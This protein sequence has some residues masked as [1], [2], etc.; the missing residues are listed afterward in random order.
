MEY[1]KFTGYVGTY[2]KGDSKGIYSFVLDT[3]EGKITD[4]QVAGT[5]E[6]PTYLTI[7]KDQRFLYSV[8]KENTKGGVAA[9]KIEL[10]PSKLNLINT[11]LSEGS[12]PCHV[13]IDSQQRYLFSTNYHKGTVESYLID[14]HTGEI[15]EPCSV[16]QHEG[17]GPDERQEKAHTHFAGMTPDEKYVVVVEL[18]TDKLFTYEVKNDGKLVEVS[19][20]S[21]RPGSGSRH[22]AFHPINNKIAYIMTEFSSEVIVLNYNEEDGTFS[23]VETHKTIPNDF[24]KNNQGSAIHISSDGKFV[25]VGNRGHNSI[26]I[27]NSDSE[28]GKLQFVK[29]VSTEGDWPRDFSLDPTEKFLIASNQNSSNL[30]LFSRDSETG[31]LELLQKDITVPDPVCVKFL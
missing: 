27:F 5:L 24:V 25:Y 18:G 3:Q 10:D 29:N 22:L 12:P 17:S 26:A 7:S 8:I 13:S 2:T 28:T 15:S 11:Q 20:L 6:N 14:Q 31:L 1:T 4:V 23:I 21:I 19:R 9:F 16:I 30:V